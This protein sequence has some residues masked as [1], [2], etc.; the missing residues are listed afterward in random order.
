MVNNMNNSPLTRR[1]IDGWPALALSVSVG[2][3]LLLVLLGVSRCAAHA[4]AT[5]SPAAQTAWYGTRVIKALDVLRDTAIDAQAQTPPLLSEAV[6]RSIVQTHRSLLET[7]HQAP[8]GWP[9]TVTAALAEL[10]RGLPPADRTIIHPY[11]ELTET[12][13]KAVPHD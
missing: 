8:S 9:A 11:V 3:T 6:T 1:L 13:L 10:E 4:P 7:I 5:L 12:L 2:V